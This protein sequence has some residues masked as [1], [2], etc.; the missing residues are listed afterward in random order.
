MDEI[1]VILAVIAVCFTIA[2]PIALILAIA[3]L[4]KNRDT[5]YRIEKL[6]SKIGPKKDVSRKPA[7]AKSEAVKPPPVVI[8]RM[9]TPSP[10]KAI[11]KPESIAKTS[12]SVDPKPIP[13]RQKILMEQ[14]IGTQ[15]ILIA[16]IITVLVGVGLLLQYAYDNFYFPPSARVIAVAVSGLFALIIGEFTRRREYEIVAKGVTA[17]GFAL[18]YASVFAAYQLHDLIEMPLAIG[19]AIGITT[20]AMVY[21]VVLDEVLIAF[22]SLLGGFATPLI[23][24]D[25]TVNPTAIFVYVTILSI[26]AMTAAIFRKWRSINIVTFIGTFSLYSLWFFD[27]YNPNETILTAI[28]WLGGFFAIYLLMPVV[29]ELIQKT[30]SQAEDVILILVNAIV[31]F[32]F[33]AAIFENS[34]QTSL[35]I[36]CVI[37]AGAHLA[38]AAVV[39][40][41]NKQDTNLRVVL[42]A[43]AI[44]F[45]TIAI[46]MYLKHY[47]LTAAWI[48]EGLILAVIGLRY[49]SWRTQFVSVVPMLLSLANMLGELPLHDQS[50]QLIFNPAFGLW[51]LE[52]AA[53]LVYHLIFRFTGALEK[54]TKI[55]VSRLTFAFFG[56]VLFAAVT[57]ELFANCEI[58]IQNLNDSRR[59]FATGMV[60]I[61]IIEM[62][63]FT[64]KP[65]SPSGAICK[66]LAIIAG[67]AGTVFSLIALTLYR[68][69]FT[70]FFNP[71]FAAALML[72]AGLLGIAWLTKYYTK[73]Q[74]PDTI[75]AQLPEAF[76]I[77]AVVLLL[78]LLTEQIWYY[79]DYSTN[80]IAGKAGLVGQMWISIA[81]AIYGTVLMIIGFFAGSRPLRYIALGLFAILLGKVFLVDTQKIES[82]Y[83]IVAFLAT[84]VTLVGISYLY[85]FLK[86]K[87]FFE[88]LLEEKI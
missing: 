84:G 10:V 9:E 50:F 11:R 16:G 82:V 4:S 49:H 28:G 14:K 54:A 83:R 19:F 65:I 77:W 78:A 74:S 81:W 76:V 58:N 72:V 8:K 13:A 71:N 34:P 29:Y 52:A 75:S 88:K 1:V 62:F 37:I 30:K 40:F 2:G 67:A 85:Q 48:V 45:V 59:Y 17:L 63:F 80:G 3:A 38:F 31:T 60:V 87:G 7:A 25:E 33:L 79:F 69:S 26:G 39:T 42:T 43:I 24:L 6:E 64:V 21:A 44:F 86:K 36:A 35:P 15:W 73:T 61:A 46:P 12:I 53:L 27:N 68:S 70:I 18:F 66:T 55:Q 22:L 23:T 51:M 20:G 32:L 47:Y 41:R 5:L 57:G 56:V